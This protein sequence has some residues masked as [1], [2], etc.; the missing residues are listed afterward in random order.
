MLH[1]LLGV[2]M[3]GV[4]NMNSVHIM[5]I[6]NVCQPRTF[7]DTQPA[8]QPVPA[9]FDLGVAVFSARLVRLPSQLLEGVP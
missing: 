4:R 8:S 5:P 3:N 7:S 1:L 6:M 2:E 9:C